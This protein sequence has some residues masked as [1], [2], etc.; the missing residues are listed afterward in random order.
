MRAALGDNYAQVDRKTPQPFISLD[1]KYW[2]DNLN[3]Y[4]VRLGPWD[5]QR[6]LFA[7]LYLYPHEWERMFKF[8]VIRNPYERAVSAFEYLRVRER[9]SFPLRF[10]PKKPAFLA[11]LKRIPSVIDRKAPRHFATHVAPMVPDVSDESGLLL[12]FFGRLENID[13]DV[14]Y[15]GREIGIDLTF[16]QQNRTMSR[17]LSYRSHYTHQSRQLVEEIY[18]DDLE[19]FSYD[20]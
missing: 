5:Y 16:P 7:K 12:N 15:I 10:L 14:G 19:I 9:S 1:P 20:F 6:A 18:G 4:R 2:N 8:A 17:A 11:F 3:N 13:Q